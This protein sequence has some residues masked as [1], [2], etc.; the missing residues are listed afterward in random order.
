MY[1][2]TYFRLTFPP[3]W[4]AGPPQAG[5][6]SD[7]VMFDGPGSLTLAAH[8]VP[9]SLTLDQVAAQ[10]I[11]NIKSQGGGDPESSGTIASMGGEPGRLL[12]FHFVMNGLNVHQL[13]AFCVH[14][15]RAYELVF[16]D[17]AGNE[18][19]DRLNYVTIISTF[20]FTSAA[21]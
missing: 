17:V 4:S 18:T 1:I 9:T 15:G 8:S 20:Q 11:A 10:I 6:D 12:E 7:L 3:G 5:T 2:G 13:D 21:G 19:V 16:A 14:N